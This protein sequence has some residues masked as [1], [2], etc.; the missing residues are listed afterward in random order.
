MR[1]ASADRREGTFPKP[2]NRLLH[3]L[4]G[5][6]DTQA[7][8][9]LQRDYGAPVGNWWTSICW[10]PGS[11]PNWRSSGAVTDDAITP[12]WRRDRTL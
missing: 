7:E 3:F 2:L 11:C 8:V 5:D 6:I 9:E 10:S 1:E 4:L 12:G